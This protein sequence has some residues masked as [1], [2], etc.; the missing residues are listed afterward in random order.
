MY[1]NYFYMLEDEGVLNPDNEMHI[2]ALHY[3][4]LPRINKDL[5]DFMG[6]WNH[7]SL[8]T[9]H[10]M[11]PLQLFVRGS[12][13]QQG[14][15]STAM[16]DL[17]ARDTVLYVDHVGTGNVSEENQRLLD[18]QERV[19]VANVDYVVSDELLEQIVAQ[20]DPL[21]G[22]TGDYGFHIFSGLAS[23]LETAST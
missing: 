3:V 17:F 19:S 15:R 9:E 7:H 8:R 4:Y 12:L 1:Y 5:Q 2:W 13:Q 11:T 14:Q 16:Q 6:Q 23:F 22:P 18:W 10:H 21:G 20:F